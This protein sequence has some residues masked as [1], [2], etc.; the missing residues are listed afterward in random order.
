MNIS[1]KDVYEYMINF[2]DDKTILNMLSVNRKFRDEEFFERIMKRRYPLLI[3]FR[4][5]GESWKHLFIRMVHI[6]ATLQEKY[7]LPYIPTKGCSPER[8]LKSKDIYRD[9]TIC[10]AVGDHVDI[11]KYL[12]EKKKIKIS[13]IRLVTTAAR[14]GSLKVMKYLLEFHPTSYLDKKFAVRNAINYSNLVSLKFLHIKIGYV[15][16]SEDLQ[17]AKQ[18]GS[19]EVYDYIKHFV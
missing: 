3:E 5:D 13:D 4:K 10:A 19:P 18:F 11:L 9:A 15:F 16:D 7:Q 2:A 17:Y 14:Y 12:I 8:L 6:L 1:D